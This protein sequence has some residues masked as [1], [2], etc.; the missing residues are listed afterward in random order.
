MY[1]SSKEL[2]LTFS[3][4]EIYQ[5]SEAMLKHLPADALKTIKKTLLCS[6]NAVYYN[7]VKIKTRIYNGAGINT[8]EMNATQI[9]TDKSNYAKDLNL[10]N[11]ISRFKNML[12]INTCIEYLFDVSLT[13]GRSISLQK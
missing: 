12:K 10:N 1:G 5:Y 6:K 2:V 7:V 8:T 9:S 4:Y 3:P 13:L 11:R